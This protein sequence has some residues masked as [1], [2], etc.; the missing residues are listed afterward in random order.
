[1]GPKVF[2]DFF[3]VQAWTVDAG[4]RRPQ[5]VS[6]SLIRYAFTQSRELNIHESE[7]SQ[8]NEYRNL[9]INPSFLFS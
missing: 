6:K 9:I 1:M 2:G 5:S 3:F 4:L 8:K 7:T